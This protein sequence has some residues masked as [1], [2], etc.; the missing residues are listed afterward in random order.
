MVCGEFAPADGCVVEDRGNGGKIVLSARRS[1]LMM[2]YG[3]L[4]PCEGCV[5]SK[6]I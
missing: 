2:I 5:L 3:R 4:P 6:K 1:C